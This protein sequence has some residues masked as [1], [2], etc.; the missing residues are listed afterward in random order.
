MLTRF[1]E[2]LVEM[3]AHGWRRSLAV[4]VM[5][6][7]CNR[8]RQSIARPLNKK[9]KEAGGKNKPGR[10]FGGRRNDLVESVDIDSS[11]VRAAVV[12]DKDREAVQLEIL[13][14]KKKDSGPAIE[15]QIFASID[16]ARRA[17]Q[18]SPPTVEKTKSPPPPVDNLTSSMA[19]RRLDS[20]PI[21]ART[22]K[23]PTKGKLVKPPV[24]KPAATKPSS[25]DPAVRKSATQPVK[26]SGKKPAAHNPATQPIKPTK[27]AGGDSRV[28]NAS[29]TIPTPK[30]SAPAL[31]F[32]ICL[33][34]GSVI[35]AHNK[36]TFPQ[37]KIL[38]SKNCSSR[39]L[40]N[41]KEPTYN[42]IKT[43]KSPSMFDDEEGFQKFLKYIKN[44]EVVIRVQGFNVCVD[45]EI[46]SFEVCTPAPHLTTADANNIKPMTGG[47]PR[48]W[49]VTL[50][51]FAVTAS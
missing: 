17:K 46:S 5:K 38:C 20:M 15:E 45:I 7:I 11:H 3:Q 22:L 14:K 48:A 29:N 32:R 18:K 42:Y 50:T 24:L 6:D 33:N 47:Y 25:K 35:P 19:E 34:K 27:Q 8:R 13:N 12:P 43:N 36:L 41:L 2:V 39:K 23:P 51:Y 28:V 10:P 26:P 4:K 44:N 31:E 16:D 30:P 21:G 40:A 37:W 49:V 9:N 1:R